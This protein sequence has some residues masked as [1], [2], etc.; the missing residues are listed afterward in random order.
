M[1]K[2]KIT[3]QFTESTGEEVQSFNNDKIGNKNLIEIF[4]TLRRWKYEQQKKRRNHPLPHLGRK[5][6]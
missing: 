6:D 5:S 1:Q 2:T 4:K 3:N